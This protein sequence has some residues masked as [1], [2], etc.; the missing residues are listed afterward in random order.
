MPNHWIIALLIA[1]LPLVVDVFDEDDKTKRTW[2]T[3]VKSYFTV[4]LLSGFA[5]GIAEL[6]HRAF[7]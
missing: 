2:K 1:Y 5:I 6:V 7:P 4:F 3:M